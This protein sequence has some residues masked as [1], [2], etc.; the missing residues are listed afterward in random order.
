MDRAVGLL[1][2]LAHTTDGAHR[3]RPIDYIIAA[4]AEAT[5]DVILWH[6]DNDLTVIC[7]FGGIPHEAEHARAEE[8]GIS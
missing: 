8:H 6:W 3:R 7:D 4:C 5:D 2:G 1:R